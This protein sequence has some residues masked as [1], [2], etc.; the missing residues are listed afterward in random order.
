MTTITEEE[1]RV[2]LGKALAKRGFSDAELDKMAADVMSFFGF[3]DSIVDNKL[4]SKYRD[5]F[6]MLEEEGLL[7]T[8]SEETQLAKGKLWRIHYWIPNVERIQD[9]VAPEKKLNPK[10]TVKTS[11][12]VYAGVPEDEWAQHRDAKK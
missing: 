12:D 1:M 4:T 6:Y 5:M 2:A 11:G 8:A 3:D 9:L 7:K 10:K